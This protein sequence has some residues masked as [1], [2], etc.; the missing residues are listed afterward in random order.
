[1]FM[2]VTASRRRS[3]Q[4]WLD[5]WIRVRASDRW[6]GAFHRAECVFRHQTRPKPLVHGRSS[7]SQRTKF[8]PTRPRSS[9]SSGLCACATCGFR[10]RA[11][12]FGQ[13]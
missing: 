6:E 11:T 4:L 2:R 7:R 1:M 10:D 12:A 9:D 5:K 13:G 8:K 3:D